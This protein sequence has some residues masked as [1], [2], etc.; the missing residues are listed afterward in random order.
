M[1]RKRFLLV[2]TSLV[3]AA[4]TAFASDVIDQPVGATKLASLTGAESTLAQPELL[5]PQKQATLST[6]L[7][8]TD[9]LLNAGPESDDVDAFVPKTAASDA[10]AM[11]IESIVGELYN[12]G[13]DV[14]R[15]NR[16]AIADFYGERDYKPVWI[17]DGVLTLSLIHI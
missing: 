1:I 15:K 14:D 10:V 8:D 16:E 17:K 4:S 7:S 13:D 6:P 2:S 12:T 9:N 11:A 3:M 5:K